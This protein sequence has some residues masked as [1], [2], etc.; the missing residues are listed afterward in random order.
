MFK[1]YYKAAAAVALMALAACSSSS[2]TG[3]LPAT[4]TS[5]TPNAGL[6]QQNY[7]GVGDSLTAGEQS[8]G[9]LGAPNA[10]SPVSALPGNA[11]PPTQE[12]GFWALFYQQATGKS[13]ASA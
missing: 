13:A 3:N 8:G 2:N 6:T 11:V 12:N 5:G 1:R 7:V 9:V 10:T 4:P